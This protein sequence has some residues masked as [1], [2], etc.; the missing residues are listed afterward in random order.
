MKKKSINLVVVLYFVALA[1][2]NYYIFSGSD[3]LGLLTTIVPYIDG[4]TASVVV[5]IA[6]TPDAKSS[7]NG[8]KK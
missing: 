4:L 3:K 2:A 6:L 8:R 5:F 7:G 1:Y